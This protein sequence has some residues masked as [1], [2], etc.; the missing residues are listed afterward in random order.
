M[1]EGGRHLV[2]GTVQLG[3]P[4]GIS[5]RSGQPDLKSA[6]DIVRTALDLGIMHFDT[7]QAYGESEDVLGRVFDTL[8]AG[9][10]V[11][12]YSKLH[13]G[14]DLSNA[15]VVRRSVDDS[16][17]KLK[18]GQLE[19]LLLHH[20]DGLRFWDRGLGDTMRG[21]VTQGKVKALGAS[22]YTPQKAYTALDIDGI[23]II[24]VPANILDRRFED[25]G[26]FQ[27]ARE[28]GQEVFIRSVYLQ[29]LVLMDPSEVPI[30][31]GAAKALVTRVKALA[32]DFGLSRQEMA[33]GY[34]RSKWPEAFIVFGA[35]TQSQVK[36][37]ARLYGT[38]L[39]EDIC[40]RIEE[41]FTG[42]EEGLL[43][44]ALWPK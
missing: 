30:P 4:Y 36:E 39:N 40:R 11:K 21:L 24:Q 29:G 12:V 6:C 20:E 34:V 10:R 1:L 38:S 44:P 9:A 37:N 28:R 7:A 16:L 14:L 13:P 5:N 33:L 2:L 26:V 22:F 41:E 35:E 3:M 18:I 27:K 42:I 32:A 8:K 17:R 15:V 31:M 23:S 19:G 25:A 43:N